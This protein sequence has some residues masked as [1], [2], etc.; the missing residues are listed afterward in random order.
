MLADFLRDID[1]PRRAVEIDD[2]VPQD[3]GRTDPRAGRRDTK[4]YTGLEGLLNYAY[5]QAGALNQFDQVGH[6]LHFSLYDIFTGPVRR[7]LDRPRPADRRA[8]ASRRRAAARPPTSSTPP[9]A[10]AGSARTSPGSTRTS[11]CRKYDPSVCPTGP[12]PQVAEQTLCSPDAPPRTRARSGAASR[13]RRAAGRAPRP[14]AR[15]GDQRR[16]RPTP[17]AT[18]AARGSSDGRTR[19]LRRRRARRHP[20]P[21]PRPAAAR[22]STTCRASCRTSSAAAPPQQRRAAAAGPTGRPPHDLLDF[23]FQLMRRAPDKPEAGR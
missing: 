23:L 9:I 20:R 4:G 15:A 13:P 14:A 18:A 3:T 17:A 10:S 7:L 12:S 19:G 5:Y 16:R 2:R 22:R 6:L 8:R 1:D 11:A 21:D